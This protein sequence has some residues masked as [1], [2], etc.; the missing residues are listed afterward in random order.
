MVIITMYSANPDKTQICAFHLK[1][2]EASRKLNITWYNKYLERIPKLVYLGVILDV[3]L[4]Y[5]EHIHK[6]KSKT[7]VRNNILRK[8]SNTKWGAKPATIKTAALALCYSTA[9]YACHVCQD[10]KTRGIE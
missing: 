3:T 7:S 4:S 9:E 1:N 5:K 8:L 6:L 10:Q 2:P